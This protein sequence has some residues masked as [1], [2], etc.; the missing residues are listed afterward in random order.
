MN[1]KLLFAFF[2]LNGIFGAILLIIILLPFKNIESIAQE[3]QQKKALSSNLLLIDFC[4]STESRH[5]RHFTMPELIAPFQDFPAY[6]EHFP[7]SSFIWY[8][9]K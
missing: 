6:H 4:L 1:R 5:T 8:P 3:K 2:I 7:S 9:Q